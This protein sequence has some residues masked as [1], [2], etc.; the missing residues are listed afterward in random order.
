MINILGKQW[1]Y[2]LLVLLLSG[3]KAPAQTID[4]QY[5]FTVIKGDS[6]SEYFSILDI[7]QL[8]LFKLLAAHPLNKKLNNLQP[9]QMLTITLDKKLNFKQ[10]VYQLS[11]R[12]TLVIK[13]RS[14]KFITDYQQKKKKNKQYKNW[15]KVV[16]TIKNSFFYDGYKAGLRRQTLRKV[17]KLLTGIVDFSKELSKGDKFILVT[18]QGRLLSVHY[19]NKRHRLDAYLY[20]KTYYDQ[21]GFKIGKLFTSPLKTYKRISS[22]FSKR[23]FHPILKEYKGHNGRD[24][25]VAAGTPIYATRDGVVRFSRTMRGFGKVVYIS[26]DQK[27]TTIYAHMSKIHKDIKQGKTIKRGDIVGFVGQTGWATGPHLHFETRIY[28]KAK[29]PKKL[30]GRSFKHNNPQ[31][32]K[33]FQ[34]QVFRINDFIAL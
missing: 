2:L 23:R 10:L 22:E 11:K 28:N 20:K 12:T 33:K 17:F 21:D 18:K 27:Y 25:A 24:Y 34:Q 30:I 5:I 13:Y 15:K 29:D 1:R 8:F 31:S 7:P 16:V 26:H 14:S 6:L 3:F 32:F 9:N 4:N 19:I